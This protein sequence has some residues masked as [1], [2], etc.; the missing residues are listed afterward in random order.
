MRHAR[1]PYGASRHARDRAV[2]SRERRANRRARAEPQLPRVRARRQSI[3]SAWCPHEREL[4]QAA[5][6]PRCGG[7][8]SST[9]MLTLY[10]LR[11]CAEL[12][13]LR[14]TRRPEL[15]GQIPHECNLDLLNFISFKKGC[16]LG[17]EIV[18]RMYYKVK[19]KKS[20]LVCIEKNITM[21]VKS[22]LP[23]CYSHFSHTLAVIRTNEQQN[24]I[25]ARQIW[26][27]DQ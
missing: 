1:P 27:Q 16:Y 7:R 24:I 18:S 5:S 23:A 13:P 12:S 10:T 19:S 6:V 26:W 2:R 8:V 14:L 25:T 22:I 11:C 21:S 9:E 17:Q 15:S 20:I 4:A 3:V